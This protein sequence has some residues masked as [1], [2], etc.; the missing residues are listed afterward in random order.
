VKPVNG[1]PDIRDA[2]NELLL[3]WYSEHGRELPWRTSTD[4][5]RV[6]VSEV[7]SHQTQIGRVVP[8]YQAFVERFPTVDHLAVASLRDVMEVWSGLGYNNRARRLHET[9]RQV[10][11]EGWPETLEGLLTLPG[12]GPYTAHAVASF[13]M[14]VRVPAVD[15]NLKRVLSRWYG[16]ELS[17][18][19]LRLAAETSL[20]DDAAA[21]NQAMM[22]LGSAVCTP[23]NPGCDRCPVSAYCA[24]P[25]VYAP[26]R[27][28]SRFEG[29]VRQVRGAIVREL[30]HGPR[31]LPQLR[32]VSG[33]GDARIETALGG[34]ID[35]DIVV[36]IEDG[37]FRL[38]D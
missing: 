15:T 9:A 13:A 25:D 35:D 28:Q 21:W 10:S 24:G 31:G 26:P 6:L 12:V 20:A 32:E 30:V 19:S 34:L 2:R 38:A 8:V 16:E 29:S 37:T 27:T 33:A 18:E 22:D 36:A 1:D 4:P 14:G 11:A 5:Y 23:R 3:A 7:M 17:G